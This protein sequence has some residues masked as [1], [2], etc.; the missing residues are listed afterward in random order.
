[1]CTTTLW[2]VNVLLGFCGLLPVVCAW[3]WLLLSGFVTVVGWLA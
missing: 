1:M 3:G 2:L